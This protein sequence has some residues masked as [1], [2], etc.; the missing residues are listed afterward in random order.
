VTDS[1]GCQREVRGTTRGKN[2]TRKG[3]NGMGEIENTKKKEGDYVG[4][5]K[6]TDQNRQKRNKKTPKG[7]ARVP[8]GRG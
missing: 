1:I 3:H 5:T 4:R 2:E 7:R 6:G 8:E